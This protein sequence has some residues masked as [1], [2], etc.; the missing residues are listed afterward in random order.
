MEKITV[1]IPVYNT[2]KYIKQCLES[3]INQTYTNLEILI[4]IDGATDNSEEIIKQYSQK[5][6][7]IQVISRENKGVLYTRLE[8][9]EKATS[10][11][12]YFVDADDWIELNTIEVMY[13]EM[14]QNKSNVVRCRSYYEDNKKLEIKEQQMEYIEKENFKEKIYMK[15]FGT[16]Q[17]SCIWNQL[18]EKKYFDE[19]KDIDFTINYGEDHMLNVG[20]YK[21]INSILLIP[22]YFYHYRT[23]NESITKKQTYESILKKMINSYKSHEEIIKILDKYQDIKDKQYYKKIIIKD[24]FK[25]LKNRIVEFLSF[26]IRNGKSKEAYVEIENLLNINGI[27]QMKKNLTEKELLQLSKDENHKY[28]IKNIYKKDIKK[29]LNYI[30]W[31]YIPGKKI[32]KLIKR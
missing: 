13:N 32:K 12:L 5:D 27:E 28:I 4:I 2:E 7:R 17:F 1:I 6:R 14:K 11:Y 16:Y 30:K 25:I 3:V 9:I 18:I 8:G 31:I 15:L 24:T 19:L 26:S 10:N 22:N 29:I 21:N 23:N 20:L